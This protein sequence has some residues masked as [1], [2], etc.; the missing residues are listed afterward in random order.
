MEYLPVILIGIYT[1]AY[2]F[3]IF[4]QQ[5]QINNQK[6]IISSCVSFMKI[7]DI[8]KVK[9]FVEMKEEIAIME[10]VKYI[11]N[12]DVVKQEIK[13][14]FEENLNDIKKESYAQ[15]SDEH[16]DLI[17]FALNVLLIFDEENRN[18]VLDKRFLKTK[19]YILDI[20]SNTEKNK[21]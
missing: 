19:Q 8:D 20:I 21:I 5:R 15:L 16:R 12:S 6:Q 1:I 11:S 10:A 7:F 4:I 17:S 2:I 13:N 9:K 3:V 14:V 18:K